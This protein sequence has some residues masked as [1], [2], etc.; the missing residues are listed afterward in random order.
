MDDLTVGYKL[1]IDLEYCN[2]FAVN[3]AGVD[4]NALENKVIIQDK[5]ESRSN[6]KIQIF[7]EKAGGSFF[8]FEPFQS[9]EITDTN[10]DTAF[11]GVI[12][13][14]VARLLSQT[15]IWDL[16]CTDNHYYVDKDYCK[17]IRK[18]N[19]WCNSKRFNYKCI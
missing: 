17:S 11:S 13:K 19:C 2:G 4:Y 7:D 15:R 9:V 1:T 18:S 10:G 16:A 5:S 3:I 6:A 14:P 12:L 8:S